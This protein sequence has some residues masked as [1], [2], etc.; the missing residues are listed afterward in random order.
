MSTPI[1]ETHGCPLC[2]A[3]KPGFCA[4]CKKPIPKQEDDIKYLWM[5]GMGFQSHTHDH[6]HT[7]SVEG[8]V[9][10]GWVPRELCLEC[11]VTDFKKVYPNE[12]IPARLIRKVTATVDVV[13]TAQEPVA[14]AVP[15]LFER[16]L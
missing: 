4:D 14:V 8:I 10:F 2:E 3:R 16:T 11:Y 9:G 6:R 7:R 1:Y 12:P 13:V 15:V 5:H